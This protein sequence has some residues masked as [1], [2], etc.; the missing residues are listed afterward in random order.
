MEKWHCFKDKVEMVK[1]EISL[2]YLGMTQ[3]IEGLKCPK[4]GEAYITAEVVKT[5]NEGEQQLEAK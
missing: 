2:A 4:C 1:G 5:V 3:D